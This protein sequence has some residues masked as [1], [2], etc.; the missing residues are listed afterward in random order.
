MKKSTVVATLEDKIQQFISS[1]KKSLL[2]LFALAAL[3][4]CNIFPNIYVMDDYAYITDWSLIHDLRNLP[5]FFTGATPPLKTL[6]HSIVYNVSAGHPLGFHVLAMLV[7]LAGVY[8]IY[9]LTA[10]LTANAFI[11]FLTAALF[12]VHPVHVE[13]ITPMTS[14]TDTLGIVFLFFAFYYYIKG[15]GYAG[16]LTIRESAAEP[17]AAN[18]LS[19]SPGDYRRALI[20][21]ALA[22]FTYELAVSLPV[23]FIFYDYFFSSSRQ[24][25]RLSIRRTFPYFCIVLVY[26]AGKW[27]ALGSM[28]SGPY[29]YDS[30]YL[31]MMVTIKAWAKYL[32]VLVFPWT[33]AHNPIISDGIFA[34]NPD[35]FSSYAVLSQS[36]LDP[37]VLISF[38]V[39]AGVFAAGLKGGVQRPWI[40][41]CLGW[42]FITLLPVA[43]IF[44]GSVYFAE[45]Y[46]Y[47]GSWVFCLLI[48]YGIYR[49]YLNQR[50]P[51]GIWAACV[52]G[53]LVFYTGRTLL[54]N[55]DWKDEVTLYEATVKAN[56]QS[57]F[58]RNDLGL[59]YFRYNE[60]VKSKESFEKAIALRPD[61]PHFYFSAEQTYSALGDYDRAIILLKKAVELNPQFAEAYFNL[62]GI[63]AFLKKEDEAREYLQKAVDLYRRQNRI[64]E[65]GKAIIGIESYLKLRS[66]EESEEGAAD[67]YVEEPAK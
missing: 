44:P 19:A 43:N 51:R 10:L 46:L 56:P 24:S 16:A 35:D 67:S 37:Q 30:F 36:P 59:V 14:V 18:H 38:F 55:Q 64:V 3:S 13:A 54:R 6:V 23:L 25:L 34:Y 45:R 1:P 41:F 33:L 63:H 52:L 31:T 50:I 7:Q 65:A 12:A 11:S 26:V 40:L 5:R 28:T 21:A 47:P 48:S 9:R 60:L 58:L 27:L 22:V 32:G 15:A 53:L 8:M 49:I 39:L 29:L 42:F 62:A 17:I 20:F 2:V 57:A 4:Y 61:E 66:D